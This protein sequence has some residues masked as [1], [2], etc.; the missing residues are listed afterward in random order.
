MKSS[1]KYGIIAIAWIIYLIMVIAEST[2]NKSENSH[3]DTSTH[4][5]VESTTDTTIVMSEDNTDES[6]NLDSIIENMVKD[7]NSKATTKL[8][9]VED[10]VPSDKNGNHYRTEFRL[11]AYIDAIGKSYSMNGNTI[12][13][14]IND[15]LTKEYAVRLYSDGITIDECKSLISGFSPL[16]D[17][18]MKASVLDDALRY[19]EENKVANGYCYGEL[20]LCLLGNDE[21]GYELKIFAD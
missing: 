5:V 18:N 3:T 4:A 7:Y 6:L 12:D 14:V 20:N 13:F 9:F 17:T 2:Y 11:G 10:F 19:I 8:I 21:N 15:T 16:F 1:L